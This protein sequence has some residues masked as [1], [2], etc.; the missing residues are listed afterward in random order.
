M[1]W[2]P[3]SAASEADALADAE[4]AELEAQA[5]ADEAAIGTDDEALRAAL[6][7]AANQNRV[8]QY[9]DD[10]LDDDIMD[11]AGMFSVSVRISARST[12]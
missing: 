6:L 9:G 12:R 3:P 4:E 10:Y 2:N 5:I 8:E 1:P 11:W 7:D